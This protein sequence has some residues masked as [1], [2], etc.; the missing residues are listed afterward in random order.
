MSTA[1]LLEPVLAGGIT[2][3]HF[4]NG[5]VLTAED[6][7][8]LQAA[9][10]L[11]RHQLGR[12]IG[13]GVV[14]GLDVSPGSG[15]PPGQPIVR[16]RHG[17]ALNR[18][19][20]AI[21]LTV[22]VDLALTS[23]AAQTASSPGGFVECV[24]VT[25]QSSL[26]NPGLYILTIAPASGL[27]GRAEKI[28]NDSSG[29]AKSCASR[30]EVSGVKFNLVPLEL[31]GTGAIGLES[32]MA[33]L[34]ATV[35]TLLEQARTFSGAAL[36]ALQVQINQ[37]LSR[38]R[39]GTAHL[40][41]GTERV[42]QFARDVFARD[43][44]GASG[45]QSRGAADALVAAGNMSDSEVPLALLL[46]AQGLQFVD[47][48]SIRRRP[49]PLAASRQWPLPDGLRAMAEAE[50]VF[51]QFQ[52]QL[53]GM[54]RTLSQPVVQSARANQFFRYL[55][56][57]GFLPVAGN[58][59]ARGFNPQQFFTGLNASGST[60][61]DGATLGKLIHDSWLYPPVDLSAP[62]SFTL[63]R[64]REN[65]TAVTTS[66]PGQRYIAFVSR[67]MQSI[68]ERD[69]FATILQATWNA[70]YG[71]VRRRVFLSVPSTAFNLAGLAA[72]G[73][74]DLEGARLSILTELQAVMAVANQKAAIAAAGAMTL[75][76]ALASFTELASA[77][78][79]LALLLRDPIPGTGDPPERVAFATT[80]LQYLRQQ[81]PLNAPGLFPSIQSGSLP[82]A[83]HAQTEIN[84][85]IGTGTGQAGAL[86]FIEAL[87]QSSTDGD[88]LVPNNAQPYHFV[89][90]VANRTNQALD[91]DLVGSVLAPSGHWDG[92]VAVQNADGAAVGSIH[93]NSQAT[94]D[95]TAVVTVPAD[96]TI[97]DPVSIVL[98]AS[99]GA[100]HNKQA[101]GTHPA[102]VAAVGGQP[103]VR[104]VAIE[105]VQLPAG[106][107]LD[108]VPQ[109]AAAPVI[110]QFT[111]RLRY[112]AAQPPNLAN[113]L[114]RVTATDSAHLADWALEFV[115]VAAQHQLP[116]QW[117]FSPLP[118]TSGASAATAFTVRVRTPVAR[119]AAEDKVLT[120]TV[121]VE[122]TDLADPIFVNSQPITLR[123]RHS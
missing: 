101:Q 52:E 33:T 17:L 48:W 71:L 104:T 44:D 13:A 30:Y 114:F 50:A 41:L 113:F 102:R 20:E 116:T 23:S 87:Y 76:A 3:P 53:G 88:S 66:S 2:D 121:R 14:E 15:S 83:I 110:L 98:D 5:R 62:A 103:V 19:G 91:I 55:P 72:I 111:F 37:N 35:L 108:N 86:G 123:L 47:A 100:P 8:E 65:E 25:P 51:L 7:S 115:G 95:V 70:Y 11:K 122:S 105:S 89:F 90:T 18:E 80:L 63:Y 61:I 57:C 82:D 34:A 67:S 119:L 79:T 46:L 75:T 21:E 16:V 32:E 97:G 74:V 1:S 59:S 107:D 84:S 93:L 94:Q 22:D 73:A 29:I 31:G 27:S 60:L 10:A 69:G 96:A 68:L 58:G 81:V 78:E 28:E 39:S 45:F 40:C 36:A 6:L 56:P 92:A 120:F 38:F 24:Q 9:A 112:T 99:V 54:M 77:Q 118:L 4:F 26:T 109:S 42:A 64:I 117:E 106:V 85:L 12:A 49:L 43:A